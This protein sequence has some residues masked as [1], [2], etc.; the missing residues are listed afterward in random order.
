[1]N[2]SDNGVPHHFPS[3]LGVRMILV[4]PKPNLLL[5]IIYFSNVNFTFC[6]VFGES[7]LVSLIVKEHWL[8]N[9]L[10]PRL[11]YF[12]MGSTFFELLVIDINDF[13][14]V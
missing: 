4:C 8:K 5:T 7:P 14:M 12:I 3:P 9:N 11:I 13:N 6:V 2:I 10:L 1:M